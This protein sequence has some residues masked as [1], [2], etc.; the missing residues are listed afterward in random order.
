MKTTISRM[1]WLILS[2]YSS[3]SLAAEVALTIDIA[4]QGKVNVSPGNF[5][6]TASCELAIEEDTVVSI[7]YDGVKGSTFSHW[8]KDSCDFGE[9]ILIESD[10]ITLF[11]QE[12][13]PKEIAFDDF[14]GDGMDDV[15]SISLFSSQ[16]VVNQATSNGVFEQK[17]VFDDFSYASS[18]VTADWDKD[19]DID[20]LVAD[21]AR[22]TI[23]P[24]MND[25]NGT[26][27][28][29][30][31]IAIE[32]E[33]IYSFAV[34]DI[35]GDGLNDL[36]LGSF[37]ANLAAPNLRA[38]IDSITEPTLTWYANAGDHSFSLHQRIS[39]QGAFFKLAVG[40]IDGSDSLDIVGSA[41]NLDDVLLF[42]HTDMGYVEESIYNDD[43]VYGV[44]LGDIDNDTKLDVLVTSYYGSRLSLLT[45][46]DDGSFGSRSITT[47]DDGLTS[48]GFSDLDGNGILD[49]AWGEFDNQV[50][51]A[52]KT[53]SYQ[54]CKVNLDA[55][56]TVAV[57]FTGGTT[58]STP[59]TTA[60]ESSGSGGGSFG[61]LGLF[62]LVG[63][64]MKRNSSL[65]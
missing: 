24:Y 31:G 29:G 57:S 17:Q 6:C 33:Y 53:S 52:L 36:L 45:Q 16:L 5:S 55:A 54:T 61:W 41:I 8:G 26:F 11:S 38:I 43:A 59:P 64:V 27:S 60:K 56:R 34:G 39:T 23:L 48:V 62:V 58:A 3:A 47:V 49:M 28:Q 22:R 10:A 65:K 13:R 35:N 63:L 50:V 51:N 4:G 18:M 40:S 21:T 46:K 32:G 2:L 44:A 42:R 15:A 37:K 20:I 30:E 9:G 1:S 19:G 12:N 7:D 14:N 25:G